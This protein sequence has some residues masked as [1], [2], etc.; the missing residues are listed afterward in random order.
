MLSAIEDRG[1]KVSEYVGTAEDAK[2]LLLEWWSPAG[3]NIC[4]ETN[5]ETLREDLLQEYEFFDVDEHVDL[6]AGHRGERGVPESYAKLVH[7]AYAIKRELKA[8]SLIAKGYE[9]HRSRI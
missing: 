8:L 7:D 2:S 4:I 9:P 3:E 1:W 6:W 5:M